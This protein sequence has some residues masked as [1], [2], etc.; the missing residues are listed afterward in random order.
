MIHQFNLE[1]LK[2]QEE[3][4][5]AD[6]GLLTVRLQFIDNLLRVEVMNARN[7]KSKDSNGTCDPYVKVHLLPEEK[8]A[9]IPKPRTKTHKKTS[10]PLFDEIFTL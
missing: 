10:F 3:M 9:L 1:R 7:L 6:L 5:N 8:F 4:E 2:E